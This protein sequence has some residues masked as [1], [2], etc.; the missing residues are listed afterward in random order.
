MTRKQSAKFIPVMVVAL[1]LVLGCRHRMEISR[2]PDYE[3]PVADVAVNPS[4]T[5]YAGF[6]REVITPDGPVWMAGFDFFRLST[7]VH[8]DLFVR[9]LVVRLGGEK[10]ALVSYDLVGMQGSDVKKIK[11]AIKGFRP[12]QVILSCTHTHSGPDTMG[13]WGL[14]PI[15]SGKDEDYMER[16]AR[17]TARAV[18]QAET[19]SRPVDAWTAVYDLDPS[20]TLNRR[21]GEPKDDTIGLMVFRDQGGAT[22]ATLI[23]MAC[24]PEVIWKNKRKLTADYPGVL[25]RLTEKKYGGGAI[26]FSGAL[27]ALIAPDLDKPEEDHTWE[28]LENYGRDVFAEVERGMGLLEKEK[29]L[30]LLHRMSLVRVP[31]KNELYTR[32]GEFGMLEREVYEK[33]TILTQVHLVE[34]G[35]AQFVTFPGEAYPKQGLNIRK[36]QKENSFQIGLADDELGYILYPEDYGSE[37]YSYESSLCI[38]P[39]L[40]V[41]MEEALLELMEE[42]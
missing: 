30:S 16:L 12:D 13:I 31:I 41:M 21:K 38:S 19:R 14:P 3:N 42:P 20:L 22:V 23:N 35:S 17:L 33:E 36:R 32:L 27:G 4:E 39:K 29:E 37:L 8:D 24:H 7:G 15:F 5:F 11:A 34:I 2:T 40:S 6:G 9:A 1:L 28:D 18:E 26:F 10:L 25:Y